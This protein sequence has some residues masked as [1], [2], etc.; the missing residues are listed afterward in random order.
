[1]PTG[2]FKDRGTAVMLNH[3]LEVG[4]G[5]IHE[6]SSGNAGA[7]I[8]TYAAAA[9]IPCR[10]Y[11]PAAAPRAKLVQIAAAGADV[12]AIPGTR[13][14]R[15]RGGARRDRRELL[16]QPQLAPVLY[17]GHQDPGLRIVGAA[18]LSRCPTTSSCRP[19]TAATSSASN[20][21]STNS[22]EPARSPAATAA[23]RGPGGE[24][25][26]IRGGLVGGRRPVC[27]VRGTPDRRRRDR[28][29]ATGAHRGGASGLAPLAR[30]R[31]RGRRRRD[32]AGARRTRPS[33]ALC[34]ADRRHRRRGA[35]QAPV[36]TA[37]SQP[38]QTTVAVL[39]GPGLKAAER[40]GELL[41]VGS[42]R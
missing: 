21:A 25:R 4:V 36:A 16:R 26:R 9:G 35:D 39:T 10:I 18:R 1:M 37:R 3:L 24:L 12:R 5:P 13:A 2:S 6:D 41:G 40:I 34:R 15:D 29:D 7:S 19:A 11:V 8:A 33:R 23:L 28:H 42:E 27:A 20:A 17:R 22:N 31:R 32:R 38:D 30:R 14:G